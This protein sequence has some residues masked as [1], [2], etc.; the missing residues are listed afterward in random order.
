MGRTK[1]VEIE[2]MRRALEKERASIEQSSAA[3]AEERNPV[4]L[5]QQTVGR[6]SRIDAIQVQ[7]MAQATEARRKDRLR[8]IRG[9]L[10]RIEDGVFG[11]CLECGEDIAPKRLALDPAATHCI[12]CAGLSRA[13]R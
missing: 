2:A 5:D 3:S 4:V 11:A 12:D 9:A 6:L 13:A 8:R 1:G 7:Q 10:K